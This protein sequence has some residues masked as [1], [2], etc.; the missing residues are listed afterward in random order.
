MLV[1]Q[2]ALLV[3]ILITIVGVCFDIYSKVKEIK[4]QKTKKALKDL[5]SLVIL[6]AITKELDKTLKE[7]NEETEKDK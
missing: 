1:I 5:L 7:N 6:S 3:A 4:E 2:I